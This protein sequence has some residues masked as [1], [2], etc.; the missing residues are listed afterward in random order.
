LARK[1]P[2]AETLKL[3]YVRSGNEC[4]FPDCNHPIFNDDGLYIAQLCHI[5]AANIGGQRYDDSQ[6]DEERRATDNLMFM[7]HRHH[8]ETDDEK[9]YTTEKL[10]KLKYNHELKYTEFGKEANRDMI[11]QILFEVNYFWDKQSKKTFELEDLKIERDFGQDTFELIKELTENIQKVREYCDICAE[12]D[13]SNKLQADLLSLSNKVGINISKFE[14]VPYYEN[15]FINRNWEM[16]NIG[17]PNFFSH[18]SLSLHQLKVK[19]V[20]ELLKCSPDDDRLKKIAEEYRKEFENIY[21][22]AYYVD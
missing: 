1:S 14:E 12:S 10:R 15:P 5:N 17:R 20:D 18:I 9:I 3:L 19:I 6:S 22:K 16:H 4:A 2:N 21:D 11:R 8:K 13:D 7:C